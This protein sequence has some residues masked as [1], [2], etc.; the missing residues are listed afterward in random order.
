MSKKAKKQSDS[1]QKNSEHYLM[2][3]TLIILFIASVA[4]S[5]SEP[6]LPN[7]KEREQLFK[8]VVNEINR[9]DGEGLIPRFNRPEDWKTTTDKLALEAKKAA[10]LYDWART[11]KRLDATYPNLHA[12]I[13]LRKELDQIAN[14]GNLK[15]NFIIAP[16]LNTATADSYKYYIR[17]YKDDDSQ[18]KSGDEVIAIN[19]KPIQEVEAENFIYCKFPLKSQCAL[20]LSDNLRKELLHW[21]RSLPLELT[22]L[23][24]Q[25]KNKYKVDTTTA[26]QKL[27][28]SDDETSCEDRASL[29]KGFDLAFKGFNL[30]AYTSKNQKNTLVLRIRT[31][32]YSDDCSICDLPS[33]VDLFWNN[34]WRFNSG[35]FKTVIF[36]VIG[37]FGGQTPIPYYGLFT[38][39]PYQEQYTQFKKIK[40]LERQDIIESLFWG[41]KAKEIWFKNIKNDQTFSK[42]ADGEFL[43]TIPQFCAD[44]TKDCREGLFKPK[45]HKFKGRIKILVDQWC[46]SSCVGFVDNM[47]K[48][49]KG[50][51]KIYGHPDSADSAY[52]RVTVAASFDKGNALVKILPQKKSRKPDQPEPWIR[53]VVSV[54]RS[55]DDKGNILSGKPQHIDYW[56]PRRW[57][58]NDGDWVKDVFNKATK[59]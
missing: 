9:L 50:R 37:N 56:I 59:N 54:T 58:Q 11:F 20:E 52:S 25:E 31:F 48:L 15:F 47:A 21:N 33:E 43:S 40:E 38:E 36:D 2:K 51:V 3:I 24:G 29:Y 30:C 49:F 27:T 13:F 32:L 22:I 41:D 19:D 57:S 16:D 44:P 12:K 6:K 14:E 42:T 45:P 4:Y 55:T 46:V 8:Q 34:Y 28:G 23:R 1:P 5:Q 39:K 18:I 7:Q 17:K 26:P 10:T 35:K 53:Q